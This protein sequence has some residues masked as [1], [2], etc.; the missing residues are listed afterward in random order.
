MNQASE[1]CRCKCAQERRFE[2]MAET[3]R[4]ELR[5]ESLTQLRD[6]AATF[7]TTLR[8]VSA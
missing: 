8:N 1:V 7:V 6:V 2:A 5:T 4:R 3:V